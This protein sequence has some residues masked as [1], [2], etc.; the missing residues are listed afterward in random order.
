[1]TRNSIKD[2]QYITILGWMRNIPQ[3]KNNSDLMAYALIYGFSQTTG[4]YLTCRQSYI[5]D[6]L[7]VSRENCNRVLKRLESKGLIKKQL[8]KRQGATKTYQYF[9]VVPFTSD[10]TSL[11]EYQNIT[12]T[13]NET[14]HATSDVLSHNDNNIY[15]NILYIS[16]KRDG[17]KQ[18]YQQDYDF[19]QLEIELASNLGSEE[20]NRNKETEE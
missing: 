18:L 9:A 10:K 4:Q 1:M 13:S 15:N 6:W 3:I 19:E 7:G 12:R 11:S 14:S 2:G 17:K 20:E 5:A 16:E 8:V